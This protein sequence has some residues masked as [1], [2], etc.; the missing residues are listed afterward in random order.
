MGV[1]MQNERR[2]Q[3][4]KALRTPRSAAVAGILFAIL[5]GTGMTIIQL[6]V[7]ADPTVGDPPGEHWVGRVEFAIGVF[8][9]AGIAFLWFIGVMRDH[10]GEYE[11]RFFATILL[12]SGFLFLAMTFVAAALAG[13]LVAIYTSG[14]SGALDSN[15][16]IFGRETTDRIVNVYAI[17]VS[18]VFMLSAG[19]MWLRTGVM[20]RWMAIL[21]YVLALSHL[22]M[23]GIRIWGTLIFPAWVLMISLYILIL[24]YHT[25]GRATE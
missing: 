1:M 13:G 23:P 25:H 22:V 12:G 5:Y 2:D 18:G 8:P 11:D 21:T 15:V 4:R 6:S 24:N 17:R 10:F 3:F 14:T 7:P 9:Y 16:Y 19:T 20:P